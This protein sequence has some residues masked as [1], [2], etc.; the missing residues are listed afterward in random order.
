MFALRLYGRFQLLA[1]DGAV[2]A[3]PSRKHRVLIAMLAIAAGKPVSRSKLAGL[4]WSE[5]SEE[6]A[7]NSLRQ[8]FFAVRRALEGHGPSPFMIDGG[9]GWIEKGA[10]SSDAAT[11]ADAAITRGMHLS[12]EAYDGE[13]L[14]GLSFRDETLEGWLHLERD[15][16][17]D[18]LVDCLSAHA[19]AM[20]ASGETAQ[21]LAAARC[22]LRHDPYHEPSHRIVLRGHLAHGERTRAIRHCEALQAL[23][24]SGLGV[25][26]DEETQGLVARIRGDPAARQ[27]Q[28]RVP[29]GPR[30]AILPMVNL[31]GDGRLDIIAETL[32]RR[33]IADM[34]RFSPVSVVAAA[35]MFALRAKDFTVDEIGR[36]V[37]ANY[38]L[39][40]SV[41][42]WEEDV[43]SVLAQL[44]SVESGTQ[45]WSRSYSAGALFTHDGQDRL[46]HVIIG[47]FYH[48]LMRHAAG[49]VDAEPHENT[50]TEQLYLQAF[51]HVER[52]TRAGMALT[53]RLCD[54][55][56]LAD[57][58]HV[59]IRECLAWVNFHSA[60]NGWTEDPQEAFRQARDVALAGLQLDDREP[61]LLS[62]L[63]LAQTFLGDAR[64]ALDAL[65]RAV[66]LNPNDAEF[67]AWLGT[68]LTCAGRFDE[69]HAAFDRAH[70]VSPDY[71]PVFL[72]R[73]DAHLSASAV[74]PSSADRER[75]IAALDRFLTI[76]PEYH[77]ARL[78][79]AAA[80]EASGSP[81][82]ARADVAHVRHAVPA[83]DGQ[84]LERLLPAR[85]VGYRQWLRQ[86]LSAAGL[87]WSARP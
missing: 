70:H 86:R 45:I 78:L 27:K 55:L 18:L 13:F 67:H 42:T 85:S 56:L 48:V 43:S 34:G 62:A 77:W 76:L 57:P 33:L 8:A 74:R 35:T 25:A 46:V 36:R 79:R 39:E 28:G 60:F 16:H 29:G 1:P 50:A 64:A 23:L 53:R 22:I 87:P 41:Q 84:Y 69:A 14:E 7:R 61:Y 10:I 31:S 51:Y 47:G 12:A 81:D 80:H 44:V 20:E 63:G 82:L 58:R 2:V 75:A 65:G 4:L 38:M 6:N 59:L 40:L 71:P 19:A 72:F 32:T 24:E 15:R 52:P 73:A 54:R 83:L 30:L 9:S 68:G 17:R 26:P 66:E 5:Q 21:A 37:N 11:L 3:I 49:D